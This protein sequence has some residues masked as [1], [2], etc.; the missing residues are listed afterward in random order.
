[1]RYIGGEGGIEC[2]WVCWLIIKGRR[3]KHG[4][5]YKVYMSNIDRGQPTFLIEFVDL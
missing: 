4:N 3:E 2:V 5:S 1:M